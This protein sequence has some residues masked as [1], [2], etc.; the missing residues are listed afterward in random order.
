MQSRT[1]NAPKPD[2]PPKKERFQDL[3]TERMHVRS[4]W[5]RAITIGTALALILAGVLSSLIP[6]IPGFILVG[7]GVILL[8]TTSQ[9]LRGLIN[10]AD[11][12]CPPRVRHSSRQ[13][14]RSARKGRIAFQ[15]ALRRYTPRRRPITPNSTQTPPKLGRK[16][17]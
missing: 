2:A 10:A 14:Q 1:T 4:F 5:G 3:L 15:R 13:C 11:R 16:R 17:T 6:V 8:G 12:R 7:I 9:T